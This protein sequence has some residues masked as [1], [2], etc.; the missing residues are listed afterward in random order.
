YAPD[1]PVR[2][3]AATAWPDEFHIG[4]GPVKGDATLSADGDL[5]EAAARLFDL[6]HIAQASGCAGIAVAPVPNQGLGLAINDRLAR[7]AAPR[8]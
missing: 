4:F 3:E 5:T 7:A 6:L 1:Q 8:G 2:L